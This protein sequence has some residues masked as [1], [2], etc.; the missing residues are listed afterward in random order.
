MDAGVGADHL[1]G[2]HHLLEVLEDALHLER[3]QRTVLHVDLRPTPARRAHEAHVA[4]LRP[5]AGG[6]YPAQRD[7]TSSPRFRVTDWVWLMRV[8]SAAEP[9]WAR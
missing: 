4:E 2:L 3:L 9:A 6:E 5:F 1:A 7:V 8:R